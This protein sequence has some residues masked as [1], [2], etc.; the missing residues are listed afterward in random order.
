MYNMHTLLIGKSSMYKQISLFTESKKVY[1]D[2]SAA[3]APTRALL[4][5]SMSDG[6]VHFITSPTVCSWSEKVVCSV[7][8]VSMSGNVTLH[9]AMLRQYA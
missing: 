2:L 5:V 7:T 3:S 1:A 9:L 6:T 4:R 8:H